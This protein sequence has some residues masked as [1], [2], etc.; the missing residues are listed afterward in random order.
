[1]FIIGFVGAPLVLVEKV[2]TKKLFDLLHLHVNNALLQF[3]LE[4]IDQK[5]NLLSVFFTTNSSENKLF[6]TL[7][8]PCYFSSPFPTIENLSLPSHSHKSPQNYFSSQNSK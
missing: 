6:Q 7:H 4:L 1:M 2:C 5:Q 8:P 3:T